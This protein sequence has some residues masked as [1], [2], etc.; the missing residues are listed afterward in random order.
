M[1]Q[2]LELLKLDYVELSADERREARDFFEKYERDTYTENQSTK[3]KLRENFNKS[4]GPTSS[5]VCPR[6]G[7]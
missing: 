7:R 3:L 6:C 4:L 2:K 1:S 5:A